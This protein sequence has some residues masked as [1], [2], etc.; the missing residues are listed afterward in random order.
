M[1]TQT[2]YKETVK[3]YA[4]ITVNGALFKVAREVRAEIQTLRDVVAAY[5]EEVAELKR[6]DA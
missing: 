3:P 5:R 1:S 2:I 6:G 4:Y